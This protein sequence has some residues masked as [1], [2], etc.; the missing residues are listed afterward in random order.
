M[1]SYLER[2]PER[3]KEKQIETQPAIPINHN[4]TIH[5]LNIT[6]S[7]VLLPLSEIHRVV[8]TLAIAHC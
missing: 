4:Q 5:E 6:I 7:I 3:Q 8:I 1:E 2:E